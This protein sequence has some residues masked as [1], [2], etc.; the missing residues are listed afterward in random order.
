MGKG[1][2][3]FHPKKKGLAVFLICTELHY[4]CACIQLFIL[5]KWSFSNCLQKNGSCHSAR[6]VA[7]NG[8]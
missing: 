7:N 4:G 3:D 2:A 6:M 1:V 8:E 5:N